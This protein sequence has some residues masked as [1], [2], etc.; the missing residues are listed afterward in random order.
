MRLYILLTLLLLVYAAAGSELGAGVAGRPS[1]AATGAGSKNTTGGS[2]KDTT[3]AGSKNITGGS[4]MD[5]TGA[6]SKHPTAGVPTGGCLNGTLRTDRIQIEFS[7]SLVEH[8]K[9]YKEHSKFSVY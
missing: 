3:E 9:R 2:S 1:K 4:K 5:A 8:G 6:G 7:S